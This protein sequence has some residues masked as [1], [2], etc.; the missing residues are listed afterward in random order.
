M[1]ST[2]PSQTWLPIELVE[3]IIIDAWSLPLSTEERIH[4]MTTALRVNKAWMAMFFRIS[5]KHVHIPCSSY[6][7]KYHAL[8]YGRS[9]FLNAKTKALPRLLC[10]SIAVSVD[11]PP[12]YISN[13]PSSKDYNLPMNKTLINLLYIL[14][15]ADPLPNLR[16][17]SIKYLNAPFHEILNTLSFAPFPKQITRLELNFT[18]NPDMP[19]WLIAA[20]YHHPAQDQAPYL[21]SIRHLSFQGCLDVV[22]AEMVSGCSDLQTLRIDVPLRLYGH[23]YGYFLSFSEDT[24]SPHMSIS[25]ESRP[26][27]FT[28]IWDGVGRQNEDRVGVFHRWIPDDE[29]E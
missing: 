4:F 11:I 12:L 9:P 28:R 7:D 14:E 29:Y 2:V 15:I 20:L 27:G 25:V 23:G 26:A 19:N 22:I 24:S 3:T 8:L 1:A 18:F 16:T 5:L 13:I 6:L 21:P 17:L 10:H